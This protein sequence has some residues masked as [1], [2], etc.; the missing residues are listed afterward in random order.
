[1]A[2]NMTDK[3]IKDFEE[4]VK[5]LPFYELYEKH[6]KKG[7]KDTEF[8]LKTTTMLQT[9]NDR[10]LGTL[11]TKVSLDMFF[12]ILDQRLRAEILEGEEQ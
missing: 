8:L 10:D 7:D 4:E 11:M 3:T 12:S 2:K 6:V 1:M 9:F 5:K